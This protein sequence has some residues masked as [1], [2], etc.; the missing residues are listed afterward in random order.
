MPYVPAEKKSMLV[1][2]HVRQDSKR[3]L[4]N[5]HNR[6]VE[7]VGEQQP[8]LLEEL[9]CDDEIELQI[10]AV[11]QFLDGLCFQTMLAGY[12]ADGVEHFHISGVAVE[13]VL[14][15]RLW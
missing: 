8:A 14:E 4:T 15:D 7:F 2:V 6:S 1:H 9:L 13:L 10:G 5:R 12:Q 3:R 11:N